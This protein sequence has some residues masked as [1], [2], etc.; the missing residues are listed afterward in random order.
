MSD[1]A[2]VIV[3]EAISRGDWNRALAGINQAFVKSPN[4][5]TAQWVLSQKQQIADHLPPLRPCRLA[6]LRS[7]TFEPVVPMLQVQAFFY[8]IDLKVQLGN[9]NTYAQEILDPSSK[10]YAY[11]PNIVVLAV[12]TRDLLPDLWYRYGEIS[13]LDKNRMVDQALKNMCDWITTFRSH[14]QA[15]L[16]LQTMAIPPMPNAGVLDGQAGEQSQVETIRRFNRELRHAAGKGKGIFVLDYDVLMSR[17]GYQIWNDEQKW[18]TM[19]MPIAAECL[20][21]LAKEYMRFILPLL[22][23]TCKVLVVDLDNTLWG[24]VIGEDGMRG[25]QL[26][27]EYPGAAYLALQ[28]V[29]LDFSRRGIALAVSSKNNLADA[30]EVLEKHPSMLLRLKNFA[31]VR[32][33]WVDKV[34]N[35]REIAKELNL[36]LEDMAF[37]DDNP[38]ERE[39]VRSQL[40][41]VC[42]VDLPSD[43]MDYA[44]ALWDCPLFERVSQSVE[45]QERGRYYL[46]ERERRG[47]RQSVSSLEDFYHSLCMEAEIKKVC[48][49]TLPRVSQLTQKTNQFNLT[50]CRLSEQEITELLRNPQWRVYCL[51]ARD[52]FGD[53]GL[54]GVAI[55]AYEEKDCN[56]NIHTFL[57]SCRVIGRALE[58]ALLAQLAREAVMRGARTLSGWYIPTKKNA[59]VKDFYPLHH[60]KLEAEKDGKELWRFDLMG[61][62]IDCPPWIKCRFLN[63]ERV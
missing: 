42:V 4:P 26:G 11:D 40:P 22:G 17:F 63:E 58:T 10:L 59:L 52:R 15:H 13:T 45:D 39:L 5:A 43:P 32:I 16:I 6:V 37:L 28:R 60:F 21:H 41:E 30:M 55:V 1:S 36:G 12:Q 29:I 19:R 33:N 44:A 38:V 49:E 7:F 48:P 46:E 14:S 20:N 31:T 50:S 51:R 53:N 3:E 54:V 25:I 24:G 23:K 27:G 8:G 56:L 2:R 18:L 9:F 57:L 61:K 62:Q 47:L 34:M 35:I